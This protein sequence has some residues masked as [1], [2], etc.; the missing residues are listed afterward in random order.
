[1]HVQPAI[2]T[3]V[4]IFCPNQVNEILFTQI[5]QVNMTLDF[6]ARLQLFLLQLLRR[7][8]LFLTLAFLVL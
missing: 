5:F 1:M 7:L 8:A 6:F 3:L 2:K 4:L